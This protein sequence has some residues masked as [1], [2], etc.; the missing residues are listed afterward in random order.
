MNSFHFS[1]PTL[2]LTLLLSQ[3]LLKLNSMRND[4]L[5]IFLILNSFFFNNGKFQL[6]KLF[7]MLCKLTLNHFESSSKLFLGWSNLR[8][9]ILNLLV[10]QLQSNLKFVVFLLLL[11][12]IVV[13]SGCLDQFLCAQSVVSHLTDYYKYYSLIYA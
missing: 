11:R 9:K 2:K 6:R 13:V 10:P 5:L 3:C 4:I 7:F 8:C 12:Y 1:N